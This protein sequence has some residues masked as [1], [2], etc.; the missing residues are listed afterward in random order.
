MVEEGWQRECVGG[1]GVEGVVGDKLVLGAYL[2]VVARLELPVPH[3]VLLHVLEGGVVV[4]PGVGVALAHNLEVFL[5][6]LQL[7]Q[8][9]PL[10]VL[11]HL[12]LLPAPLLALRPV[13]LV[14]PLLQ[15]AAVHRRGVLV[16]RRVVPGDAPLYLR[17]HSPYLPLQL[18]LALLHALA[19]HEA[20]LVRFRLY[21]CPV[22]VLLP[23]AHVSLLHQHHHHLR[24]KAVDGLPQVLRPEAVDSAEVRV[25]VA[26]QP[27]VLD[28]LVH[29]TFYPAARVDVVH[30][31]EKQHLQQHPRRVAAAPASL[32]RGHHFRQVEAI[33]HV[34]DH[35]HRRVLRDALV[36]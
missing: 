31:R 32:V 5:I 35:S 29:Q 20:V 23:Q 9:L 17:Q 11:H 19:P 8:H 6:L 15:P 2:Q 28:V 1:V 33:H 22:H 12:P 24:E 3:V 25:L 21:L 10:Q 4:G 27:H 13:Q 18:R 34:V 14:Y 36:Q 26:R 7:G 16:I 30:V